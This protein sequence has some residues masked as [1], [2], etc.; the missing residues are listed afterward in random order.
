VRCQDIPEFPRSALADAALESCNPKVLSLTVKNGNR[1]GIVKIKVAA[2][3]L[4]LVI[5][6]PPSLLL[7]EELPRLDGKKVVMVIAD[8]DFRDEE[9]EVPKT[10]LSERGAR[11]EV[12]STTK[13]KARGMLGLIVIPDRLIKEIRAKDYDAVI[14]VGG[15]GAKTYWND[16]A[17][18]KLAGDADEAGKV[19]GAICIAPV[20]LA[21]AGVLA[22]RNATV[23]S[24]VSQFITQGGSKY[25]GRNVETDGRIITANGPESSREFALALVRAIASRADR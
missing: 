7:G 10:I 13:G 24:S 2:A 25:T 22:G 12:A 17:A 6:C 20:I 11:I 23:Y 21:N 5:T 18:H 1:R 4:V 16:P 14:F 15:T 19:V 9:L 8:K 3:L